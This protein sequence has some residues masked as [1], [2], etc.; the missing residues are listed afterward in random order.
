MSRKLKELLFQTVGAQSESCD[1]QMSS[2]S[3]LEQWGSW[4]WR[5]E[6]SLASSATVWTGVHTLWNTTGTYHEHNWK[7]SLQFCMWSAVCVQFATLDKHITDSNGDGVAVV[8]STENE[9]MYQYMCSIK[10]QWPA[11]GPQLSKLVEAAT[12]DAINVS[13]SDLSKGRRQGREQHQAGVCPPTRNGSWFV[14]A[15][16]WDELSHMHWVFWAYSQ[17]RFGDINLSTFLMQ[18]LKHQHMNIRPHHAGQQSAQRLQC[19]AWR[20][21]PNLNPMIH[22]ALVK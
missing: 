16:I 12:G 9:C 10:L 19:K 17:S 2:F 3:Q 14:F 13:L 8:N 11:D 22:H 18:Q 21:G 5:A 4:P 15:N 1:C 7:P 20:E 6:R